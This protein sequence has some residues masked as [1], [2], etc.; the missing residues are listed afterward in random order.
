MGTKMLMLKEVD[1]IQIFKIAGLNEVES[2]R[3]NKDENWAGT[4]VIT[5]KK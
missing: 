1:W 3:S 2:W 5:G 4:L